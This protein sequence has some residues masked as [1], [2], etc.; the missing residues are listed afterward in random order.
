MVIISTLHRTKVIHGKDEDFQAIHVR[1]NFIFGDATRAFTKPSF[2]VSKMLKVHFIGEQAEDEGGPRR[3]FFQRLMKAAFQCQVLFGGWP[4]HTVPVHN[5]TAI[6]Q[7]QFFLVGMMI[8]TSL[9]QEGQ[10]P[11]CFSST[12]CDYLI[13]ND[14]RSKPGINDS[15]D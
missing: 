15:E 10:P 8:A 14:V 13:F 4:Y 1:R 3:E 9:I 7:N 2:D 11:V 6:S 12:V 5:I